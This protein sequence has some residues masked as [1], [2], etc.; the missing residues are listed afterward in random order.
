MKNIILK[1]LSV[2]ILMSACVGNEEDDN[3]S[4]NGGNEL[5]KGE[6][7]TEC[8]TLVN[9]LLSNP[10]SV[11]KS[12]RYL[13]VAD[14]NTVVVALPEGNIAVKLAG[15]DGARDDQRSNA[16]SKL[17]SFVTPEMFYQEAVPGCTAPVIGGGIAAVGQ[18][19]TS[20]GRNLSEEL[21]KSGLSINIDYSSACSEN[22]LS[23]CYEIIKESNEIKSA[24]EITDFLWKPEAD[25]VFN[26]GKPVIHVN[27]CNATVYVN[28]QALEDYGPGNGRCNTSRMFSSCGS[29]G[30]NIKVEVRDNETGLPYLHNGQTFV[31]VPNGCRRFEFKK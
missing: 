9:G 7:A 26:P 19:F 30:T 29:Y 24:G 20:D 10:V 3:T 1:S 11:S 21:L 5:A 18:L 17:Q 28:G 22:L 13:S 23:D 4:D 15:I 6:F 2:L 31:T 25:S 8:G 16:I 14:A 27:P 12:V